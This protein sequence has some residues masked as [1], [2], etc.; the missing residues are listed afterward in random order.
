MVPTST[1][2]MGEQFSSQGILNTLEKSGKDQ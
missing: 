2:K 1:G